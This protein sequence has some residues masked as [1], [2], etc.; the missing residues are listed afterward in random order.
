MPNLTADRLTTL[1]PDLTA[2]FTDTRA[3]QRATHTGDGDA[4]WS[5]GSGIKAPYLVDRLNRLLGPAHWRI[6][7]EQMD[8]ELMADGQYHALAKVRVEF[9]NPHY[10]PETGLNAWEI[11][12]TE[13]GY[14]EATGLTRGD[15]M[16]G[17]ISNGFKKALAL[18]GPGQEAYMGLLDDPDYL[19]T[20]VLPSAPQGLFTV[21]VKTG[22]KEE[23]KSAGGDSYTQF[24]GQIQCTDSDAIL[25][26]TARGTE[27]ILLQTH[28]RSHTP[29][30]IEVAPL[31]QQAKFRAVRVVALPHSDDATASA[32]SSPSV[33][34]PTVLPDKAVLTAEQAAQAQGLS[35]AT[36]R[37]HYVTAEDTFATLADRTAY[38]DALKLLHSTASK[39]DKMV[40]H[41]Q[42]A[43]Q[44]AKLAA[45][46]Q[47]VLGLSAAYIQD[48]LMAQDPS[49]AV[50]QFGPAQF[51]GAARQIL[52]FLLERVRDTV[53][54]EG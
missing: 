35:W 41:I 46:A 48:T 5:F 24:D 28:L 33:A 23:V 30:Q 21:L 32:P 54:A 6:L 51:Q 45:V 16:K 13:F 53:A 47:R 12:T 22:H 29:C 19:V 52:T 17:A 9:G 10:L 20:P 2:P 18:K 36:L 34:S 50:D 14:G 15:A 4:P 27:A 49:V 25:A 26:V 44:Y 40:Q 7:E 37:I 31:D 42:S 1:L 8:C 43:E 39:F 3:L 38:L 11:L